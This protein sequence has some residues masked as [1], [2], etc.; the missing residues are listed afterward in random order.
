[1]VHFVF[2]WYIFPVWV[3]FTKKNLATL[4]LSTKL[5]I[6]NKLSVQDAISSKVLPKFNYPSQRNRVRT[7]LS[8]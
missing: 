8:F 2:I 4:F 1:L 3:I 6:T 7:T 5:E